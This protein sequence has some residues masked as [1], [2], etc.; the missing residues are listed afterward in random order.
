MQKFNVIAIDETTGKIVL[1]NVAATSPENAFA[2]AAAINF[3]L[4]MIVAAR[5]GL[6]DDD[7]I[8]FP[9]ESIVD[10]ATVLEQ[11][12]VFGPPALIVTADTIAEVL[13][14]YSLRVSNSN[15][16][17]FEDMA[18]TLVDEIDV[19][20]ILQ[21]AHASL[22]TGADRIEREQALYNSLHAALVKQGTIEF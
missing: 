14:S 11:P 15:G 18:T 22:D 5:E 21:A 1:V 6:I 17:R 19:G 4:K 9:G 2:S 3:N 20:E 8:V 16:Q 10:A 13:R 7:D 12:E